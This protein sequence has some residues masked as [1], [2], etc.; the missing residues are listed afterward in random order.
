MLFGHFEVFFGQLPLDFGY[1]LDD[2]GHSRQPY[3]LLDI[4]SCFLDILRPFFGQFPL[5]SGHSKI[6]FRHLTALPN[7]K[8]K[9][10]LIILYISDCLYK[11]SSAVY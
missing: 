3:I 11:V 5:G 4:I 6:D 8:H 2:F 10:D 7:S 1:F 9:S